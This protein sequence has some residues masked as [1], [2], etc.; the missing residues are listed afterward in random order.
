MN[1]VA[2]VG[3]LAAILTTGAWAPQLVK[4]WRTRSTGDISWTYLAALGTGV[5]LWVT[6]GAAMGDL[7]IILAN[8]V[9]LAALATLAVIKVRST[10]QQRD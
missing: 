5:A 9:T 7:A 3:G 4:C 1:I 6:Y 8:S 2:I 10:A